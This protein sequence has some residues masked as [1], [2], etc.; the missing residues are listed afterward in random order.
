MQ[1]LKSRDE[2]NRASC[3]QVEMSCWELK[4]SKSG[5]FSAATENHWDGHSAYH[6][7]IIHDHGI[8]V[9]IHYPLVI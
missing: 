2:E 7:L 6:N 1:P 9:Y 3:S 4:V 8:F 5:G